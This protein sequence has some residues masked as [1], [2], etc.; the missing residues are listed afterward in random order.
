MDVA[1]WQSWQK[2]SPMLQQKS[3]VLLAPL[4][5]SKLED[6]PNITMNSLVQLKY[7]FVQ[8]SLDLRG[9]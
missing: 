3:D 5:D 8:A 1:P 6:S 9:I 7:A 2:W 4:R